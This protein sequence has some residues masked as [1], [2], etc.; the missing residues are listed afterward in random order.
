M[1]TPAVLPLS[2]SRTPCRRGEGLPAGV[3]LHAPLLCG[4]YRE[5]AARRQA[6]ILTQAMKHPAAC[7]DALMRTY[8]ARCE[9][10]ETK[11]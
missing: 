10:W 1:G 11:I 9:K 5:V 7:T 3:G 6:R 4:L 2:T 8:A